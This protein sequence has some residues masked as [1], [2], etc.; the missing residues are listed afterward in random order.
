MRDWFTRPVVNRVEAIRDT[1]LKDVTF[2][3]KFFYG[4]GP[5]AFRKSDTVFLNAPDDYHHSDQKIR[6][7]IRYA[8][9][10]GYDRLLKIDDDVYAYW[11]RITANVPSAD[12]VGGGPFG[13]GSAYCSGAAYW[14]S[15]KAMEILDRARAGCWAEDRWVGETLQR[16]NI[17]CAFDP[18]YFVALQ[19]RSNQYISDEA[20]AA[21][22]DYITI[23]S[24]SPDQMRREHGRGQPNH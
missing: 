9:E 18:R 7:V 20:L 12:Y 2:D 3:Y 4:R 6:G 23:H 1:W 21:T 13:P 5:D 15:R 10:H 11:N 8:L 19:T 24:L 14:L 16:A 22:H 17:H